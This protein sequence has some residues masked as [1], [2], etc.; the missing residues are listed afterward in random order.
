MTNRFHHVLLADPPGAGKTAQAILAC[1]AIGAK[2][3]LVVC[4][5]SLRLNWVREF[6]MW[7]D[8]AAWPMMRGAETPE[9]SVVVVSYD[10]A[11]RPSVLDKLSAQPWDVLIL[12]E[13]H[14]LKSSRSKRTKACLK[15][16][17]PKAMK[18]IAITG[19]PLPNGRALELQPIFTAFCPELFGNWHK[20]V[21]RYCIK[22]ITPWGVQY[23]GSRNLKELGKLARERFMIRRSKEE[24]LAS[25]PPLVRQQVPLSL[26]GSDTKR[27]ITE[28]LTCLKEVLEAVEAGQSVAVPHLSTLR[29]ELGVAKS[30]PAAKFI[31]DLLEE[32]RQV[33]VMAHH[34]EVISALGREFDAAGVTF[35]TLLGDT[36]PVERQNAVNDFQAGKS[37]VFL[38]SLLAASV[39]ITLTAARAVVLV[40]SSWVP[41]DNEQAEGR[42]FRIGQTDIT[43][44]FYLVV[45][46]SLDEAVTSAVIRKQRNIETTL[47]TDAVRDSPGRQ[48]IP[49]ITNGETYG[50]AS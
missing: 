2:T 41:S 25:L 8:I 34:K 32:E 17:A 10:L 26:K 22:E 39:G 44:I 20:F 11:A 36:P 9:S 19:T 28:S 21:E 16:L 30:L 23:N 42:C 40:E 1:K 24:V 3:I 14:F 7:A 4:P 45:P 27:L 13:V 50:K 37:R 43:R 47:G 35:V 49:F 48:T 15:I 6:K 38:G 18:V 31:L 29:R 5:A 46:D 12:D 33:V